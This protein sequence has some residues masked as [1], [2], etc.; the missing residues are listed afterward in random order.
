MLE[1]ARFYDISQSN[2]LKRNDD[3]VLYRIL[4]LWLVIMSCWLYPRCCRAMPAAPTV[5]QLKQQDG[6]RVAAR[7]WGD[8]YLSGWETGDGYTIV[9]DSELKSLRWV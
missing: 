5:H 6:A 9:F 7:Q 1:S 2:T 4:T 8:E 3:P